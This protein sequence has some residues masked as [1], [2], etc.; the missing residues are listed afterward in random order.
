MRLTPHFTL[1]ELTFSETATRLG[2]DN[3]PSIEVKQNLEKLALGLE[4]VS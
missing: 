3:T 4:N 2:I 1:E